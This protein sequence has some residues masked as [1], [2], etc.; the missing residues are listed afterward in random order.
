[1]KSKPLL[2]IDFDGTLCHDRFWRSLPDDIYNK[3]NLFVRDKKIVRS[4]MRGD[5]TSEEVNHIVAEDIGLPYED[6][7]N[8]FVNDA[9]NMNISQ[10]SLE[11]ISALR[12]TYTVILMTDNMDSFNRFT[13]P[14]LNLDRYFDYIWNSYTEK[15][16]KNDENGKAF[17]D[18]VGKFDSKIESSIL[19]DNSE[20]GCK[21]FTQLGGKS[22]LVSNENNIDFWLNELISKQYMQ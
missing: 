12:E 11:T 20:S 22:Y 13:I 6:V 3:I 21:L 10:S 4:W 14:S 19:I 9:K 7:W 2:F 18:L 8:I 15:R 17:I 1:M 5:Y 16:G